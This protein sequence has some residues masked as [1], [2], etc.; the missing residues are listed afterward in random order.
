[1]NVWIPSS[2]MK[3]IFSLSFILRQWCWYNR[4]IGAFNQPISMISFFLSIDRTC[5]SLMRLAYVINIEITWFLCVS[6][7]GCR[8]GWFRSFDQFTNINMWLLWCEP[9]SSAPAISVTMS[10]IYSIAIVVLIGVGICESANLT[11]ITWQHGVNTRASLDSALKS[12]WAD[13]FDEIGYKIKIPFVR[14]VFLRWCECHNG[15]SDH[16][17]I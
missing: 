1:M 3:T 9:I 13:L 11:A 2:F 12:K 7:S 16:G 5:S 4:K 6:I 15:W 10:W 8:I 14:R 17:K